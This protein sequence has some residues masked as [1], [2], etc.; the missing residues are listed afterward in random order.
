M[1]VFQ[2]QKTWFLTFPTLSAGPSVSRSK[3]KI[4]I[5]LFTIFFILFNSHVNFLTVCS[6][7][8]KLAIHTIPI[9]LL[10]SCT[11]ERSLQKLRLCTFYE[12]CFCIFAISSHCHISIC[13][14][15]SSYL[16]CI[17]QCICIS[18]SSYLHV[19]LSNY[20]YMYFSFAAQV[21]Y[22]YELDP[23]EWRRRRRETNTTDCIILTQFY[24]VVY[25]QRGQ[26][27]P[28]PTQDSVKWNECT[29]VE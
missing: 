8:Y 9:T 15:L 7:L 26:T 10:K 6:I 11:F 29:V 4:Y 13:I 25:Q 21:F 27:C 22:N 5:K 2:K 19:S 3:I 24:P 12:T 23:I 17:Q 28:T 1:A 14:S 18:L 16:Y 20:L